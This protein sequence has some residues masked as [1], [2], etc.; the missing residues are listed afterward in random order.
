MK[1]TDSSPKWRSSNKFLSLTTFTK[2]SCEFFFLLKILVK[3]PSSGAG[4]WH[5][6]YL[7]IFFEHHQPHKD[8]R[9]FHPCI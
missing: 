7:N 2:I 3:K 4:V 9:R 6:Y 8:A 1:Y 5:D